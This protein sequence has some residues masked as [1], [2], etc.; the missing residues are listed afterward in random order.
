MSKNE[1]TDQKRTSNETMNAMNAMTERT[2][3]KEK[4]EIHAKKK[5]KNLK[6]KTSK[7]E[8]YAD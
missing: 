6:I 3:P 4:K 8:D 2:N 1:T 5:R 7:K